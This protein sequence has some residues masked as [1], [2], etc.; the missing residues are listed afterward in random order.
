MAEKG[1][2]NGDMMNESFPEGPAR[3]SLDWLQLL[4]HTGDSRILV[5]AGDL[6]ELFT[7]AA[8][9]M[10]S[11][12]TDPNAVKPRQW[13]SLVVTAPDREALLVRWLSELNLR[14]VTRHRLYSRFD[15]HELSDN[16]LVAEV[17]GEVIE[18][19]RHEVH[20][21]IKAVTFHRLRLEQANE[22]WTAEIIFDL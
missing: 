6:E 16:Q 11:I 21:E 10:F 14:H 17:G 15:I 5:R 8:W 4:D 7:R 1:N 19:A 22:E 9:G 12:I 2:R 18:P 3:A 13:E 20:T